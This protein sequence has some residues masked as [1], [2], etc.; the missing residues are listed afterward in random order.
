MLR[1]SF[2]LTFIGLVV[3]TERPSLDGTSLLGMI[4][5]DPNA[6][7]KIFETATAEKDKVNKIILL[8]NNLIGEGNGEVASITKKIAA[9]KSAMDLA[10][11]AYLSAAANQQTLLTQYNDA[12]KERA[13][14]EGLL[15]AAKKIFALESP[16]LKKEIEVFGKVISLLNSL[17]NGKDLV[18]EEYEQVK[19]FISIA[20]QADPVKVKRIIALLNTLLKASTDELDSLTAKVQAAQRTLEKRWADE[21]KAKGLW[22]ASKRVT[23]NKKALWDKAKGTYELLN[24]TGNARIKVVKGEIS[25]LNSVITLLKKVIE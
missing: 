19:A 20:D 12:T 25:T 7:V 14:A 9:A 10:E 22:E 18:E 17:L 2:L 24:R 13:K 21:N 11:K 6:L 15:S 23:I 3:A 8:L 4:R 16:A 1:L 5:K